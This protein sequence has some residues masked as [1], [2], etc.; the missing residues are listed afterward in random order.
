MHYGP[1]GNA[2]LERLRLEPLKSRIDFWDQ[3]ILEGASATFEN[4]LAECAKR[5]D[6][7]SYSGVIGH[8][9]GCDLAQHLV[10]R[11]K[12][13]IEELIL[14]SPIRDLT[15]GFA[16]FAERIG[17]T[18]AA[19]AL[20]A[21]IAKRPGFASSPE[22]LEKFW[23]VIQ[24]IMSDPFFY[25]A[26]WGTE[27][28]LKEHEQIITQ[29]APLNIAMWQAGLNDFLLNRKPAPSVAAI[30]KKSVF[31]GERDPYY[32]KVADEERFWK[33][34]GYVTSVMQAVGHYTH[35]E[36]RAL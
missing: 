4:L 11:T 19:D 35:I 9:F 5:Y 23:L 32:T 34:L 13:P 16:N 30:R 21:A 6:S 12:R 25:K 33:A 8:S 24:S 36:G 1:G 27:E 29:L 14:L 7:G 31:L 2:S 10:G 28:K 22:E 20:K 18:Q 26:Y 17:K 15:L 3:P